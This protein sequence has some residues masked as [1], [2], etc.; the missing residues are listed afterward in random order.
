MKGNRRIFVADASACDASAW[1][2]VAAAAHIQ[3]AR[4]PGSVALVPTI[5]HAIDALDSEMG[6]TGP[7]KVTLLARIMPSI[8]RPHHAAFGS[9][10]GRHPSE[11]LRIML[12]DGHVSDITCVNPSGVAE[13]A[14]RDDAMAADGMLIAVAGTTSD[15]TEVRR[16]LDATGMGDFERWGCLDA[17][18]NPA[19]APSRM[20]TSEAALVGRAGMALVYHAA[21]QRLAPPC[22]KVSPRHDLPLWTS[23][24]RAFA[25]CF[26]VPAVRLGQVIHGVDVLAHHPHVTISGTCEEICRARQEC[27]FWLH[28]LEVPHA[29][30]QKRGDCGAYEYVVDQPVE[31]RSVEG[32]FDAE[33]LVR[34]GVVFEHADEGGE[35]AEWI[36][37]APISDQE[38][39]SVV[40]AAAV[41]V[42]RLPSLRRAASI[43]LPDR[44]GTAPSNV[45]GFD[46]LIALRLLRRALL[47]E[48]DARGAFGSAPGHGSS[49]AWT[50]AHLALLLAVAEDHP[51][52]APMVA[53]A[54]HDSGREDDGDDILHPDRSAKAAAVYLTDLQSAPL[55]A[56]CRMAT[57]DAI[58]R[59]QSCAEPRTA[60]EAVLRDADRLP[61]AWE[62]GY[63]PRYFATASGHR[64]AASGPEA[65]ES[66]FRER[67]GASLFWSEGVRYPDSVRQ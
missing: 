26:G 4:H 65:A 14:I 32:R 67:F 52:L 51:P 16:L 8:V 6:R 30:L 39:T 50:I 56:S 15:V 36:R 22:T 21:G 48:L 38:W 55:T 40:G 59:H 37:A 54:L 29:S 11:L 35:L 63:E 3:A 64:L 5:V 47:P 42:A 58:A 43:W 62:R 13:A 61:L 28:R 20:R 66:E 9:R 1:R 57:V 41:D 24:S 18:S 10:I 7:P 53:A 33:E 17:A 12:D 23:S 2:A 46:P 60:L 31:I 25:A 44:L 19:R 34:M 45:P 49:H 27:N